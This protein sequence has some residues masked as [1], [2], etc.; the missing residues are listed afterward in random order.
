MEY[1]NKNRHCGGRSVDDRGKEIEFL[2]K[3]QKPPAD[4]FSPLNLAYLG[5]AVFSLLARTEIMRNGNIP[6]ERLSKNVSGIVKASAQSKM[7]HILEPL[8]SE[9]ELSVMKRGRNAKTKSRAKNA[10]VIDYRLATG[11]EALFGYLYLAGE[12]ARLIELFNVAR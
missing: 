4:E 9:A 6:V 8:L 11:V 7:Y 5:D 3:I 1:F 10:S 12:Y 2:Q